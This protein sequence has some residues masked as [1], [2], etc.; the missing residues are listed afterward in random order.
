ML[1]TEENNELAREGKSMSYRDI[2]EFL[3]NCTEEQL[4]QIATVY[5]RD[6]D[7]YR[8]CMLNVTIED[9]VLDAGHIVIEV[10]F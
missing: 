6:S 3:K 7:E 5:L 9:D 4:Q 10:D 8:E 2:L 1:F